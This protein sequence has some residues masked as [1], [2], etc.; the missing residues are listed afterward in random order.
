MQI[1][2]HQELASS[3]ASITFSSIPQTFTDLLLVMSTRSSASQSDDAIQA[4]F[5]A[6][7]S[8]YDSRRLF[9]NGSSAQSGTLTNLSNTGAGTRFM[10]GADSAA[11]NTANTFGNSSLYI[12]NYTSAAAKS[13]STDGVAENNG[14]A[15]FQMIAASTWSGTAAITSITLEHYWLGNFVQYSSATLYGIKSGSDG[16][17]SVS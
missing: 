4:Y 5:N 1:I 10:A 13:M 6:S 12:P 16:V 11:N 8:G 14:T 15:S 2:Q 3:Q 17:T 7:T 9:G